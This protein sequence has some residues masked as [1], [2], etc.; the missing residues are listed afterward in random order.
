MPKGSPCGCP[1][2]HFHVN[3]EAGGSGGIPGNALNCCKCVPKRL[4]VKVWSPIGAGTGSGSCNLLPPDSDPT[5]PAVS[6]ILAMDCDLG[7]WT[8]TLSLDSVNVDFSFYFAQDD[9]GVC[10]F[11]LES[12]VLNLTTSETSGTGT[13]DTRLKM[14]LPTGDT[15]TATSASYCLDP[16]FEFEVDLSS[17]LPDCGT[18]TIT[19]AAADYQEI[20]VANRKRCTSSGTGT[21][22]GGSTGT[23][24]AGDCSEGSDCLDCYCWCRCIC[25][26]YQDEAIVS[27]TQVCWDEVDESWSIIVDSQVISVGLSCDRNT[28][29]TKL[30]L[31]NPWSAETTLVDADCPDVSGTWTIEKTDGTPVGIGVTCSDCDRCDIGVTELCGCDETIPDILYATFSP[32]VSPGPPEPYPRSCT[33][34]TGTIILQY[35]TMQAAWIGWGYPFGGCNTLIYLKMTCIG[36]GSMSLEMGESLATL[37]ALGAAAITCDPFTG[38]WVG[39]TLL[40]ATDLCCG[41]IGGVDY[42]IYDITITE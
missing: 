33:E 37:N 34:A 25:I 6:Q 3:C 26:N 9:E 1:K 10:W 38:E 11:Y 41:T 13:A 31:T 36:A 8:G 20:S 2:C 40:L 7:R 27:T 5:G 4:C 14:I 42:N 28:G 19:T 35:N 29:T 12:E 21:G 16:L 17:A 32:G 15:G 22:S 18:V 39:I 30:S 23:G 24:T